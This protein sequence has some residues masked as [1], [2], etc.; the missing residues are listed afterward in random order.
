MAEHPACDHRRGRGSA[1]E[2]GRLPLGVL[3]VGLDDALHELVA[4]D[5]LAAEAHELDALD[6]VEYVADHDQPRT[7]LARQVDLGDVPVTTILI[8]S[9]GV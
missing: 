1:G 4:H 3:V 9:P 2:L 8:R 7:L 6:R 5:V